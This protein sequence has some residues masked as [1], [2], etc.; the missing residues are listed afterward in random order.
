[1]SLYKT[2]TKKELKRS[3]KLKCRMG[4]IMSEEFI[5]SM[6]EEDCE[7]FQVCVEEYSK[8]YEE[9]VSCIKTAINKVNEMHRLIMR[10]ERFAI[11]E[12]EFEER[13]IQR[14]EELFFKASF[15][16]HFGDVWILCN[17]KRNKCSVPVAHFYTNDGYNLYIKNDGFYKRTQLCDKIKFVRDQFISYFNKNINDEELTHSLLIDTSDLKMQVE[18]LG[19][20]HVLKTMYEYSLKS[21]L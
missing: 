16:N 18:M 11:E 15:Y 3:M 7:W 21:L 6:V 12:A 14:H 20:D 2:K 1:M 4:Y 19:I 17:V 9:L 8:L 10:K 13:N 5:D